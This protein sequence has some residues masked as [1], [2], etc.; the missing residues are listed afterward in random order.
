M[1]TGDHRF[2]Q[3]VTSLEL[4]L[5]GHY[6]FA[7]VI[8]TGVAGGFGALREPGTPDWRFLLR[9]AYAPMPAPPPPP[10]RDRDGVID[11][12]DLCPDDPVGDHPI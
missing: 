5:G 1:V 2:R 12:E 3:E 6:N 7:R 4:L 8:Q 10:D 11:A 9:L